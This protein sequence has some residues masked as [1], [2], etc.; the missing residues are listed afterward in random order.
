MRPPDVSALVAPAA[1]AG[2]T[3]AAWFA[4]G[5][6]WA[7]AVLAALA[8]ALVAFHLRFQRLVRRWASGPLDAPVPEGRGSWRVVFDAIHRRVRT[9]AGHERELRDTI[10]R[11]RRAADAIPDGVVVLDESNAIEWANPSAGSQLG[12]DL[13][14]DRG[15]P[16]AN[17]VRQPEFQAY[18][19]AG[20][21][22]GPVLV[23]GAGDARRTLSLQM[24]P[25]GLRER[26]L[27]SRDVTQVEAAARMRRDFIA[28]VSHELKTPLTVIAGF[29][30]TMQ[31]LDLD[32]S[33]RARYLALMQ[34]QSRSM[35]RLVNDLLTLSALESESN[36][37][38]E[39]RFDVG[40]L[41]LEISADAKTLSSGRHAIAL[42]IADPASVVGSREEL[43]SAYANL[44][45]N[46]IRYTPPGGRITLAWRI[47][48]DGRGAYSVA[49]T[50]IGIA[51]EHLPRLTERFYRVDR[52]RSRATGG[53]GLGLAIVKHV[54]IR[55]Q[56]ELGIESRP[57][58]GSTFTV[59]L[60]AKRVA[61]LRETA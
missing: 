61:P 10:E 12:L 25:Y 35:Q 1:I 47:E 28:N 5:A 53:T 34:D 19:D 60:P 15:A 7:L 9:R 16:I 26:L 38:G 14:R 13:A 6:G 52:S 11:F 4:G 54:L 45:S 44:V 56:A 23:A 18:L 31:D 41:L 21:F 50:G 22:S 32:A 33:R 59:R 39:D 27:L 42:D 36:P 20:D 24:V 43:A 51:P 37:P 17:L 49:D 58:V 8:A 30:E 40:P 29:V 46:A 55:H 2:A 48:P 57:G 3:V